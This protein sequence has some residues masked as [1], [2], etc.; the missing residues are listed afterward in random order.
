MKRKNEKQKEFGKR[1]AQMLLDKEIHFARRS[2]GGGGVRLRSIGAFGS[3]WG[4]EQ[5]RGGG[6]AWG[7]EIVVRRVERV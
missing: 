3:S 1:T 5:G 4:S 2:V 6:G 7:S